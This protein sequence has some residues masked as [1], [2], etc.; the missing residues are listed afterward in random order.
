VEAPTKWSRDIAS[1]FERTRAVSADALNDVLAG[2]VRGLLERG[3][4]EPRGTELS[5]QVCSERAHP[6]RVEW[7]R[8]LPLAYRDS[9]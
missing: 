5:D 1:A 6:G 7:T 2:Q 9:A 4:F 8:S 3:L